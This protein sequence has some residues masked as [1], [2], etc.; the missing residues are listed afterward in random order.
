[1]KYLIAPAALMAALAACSGAV[2]FI[3]IA[4]SNSSA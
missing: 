1:M 4:D 2:A 3:E